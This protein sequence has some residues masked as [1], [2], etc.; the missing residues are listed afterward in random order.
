MSEITFQ[1]LE[2]ALAKIDQVGQGEVTFDVGDVPVTL[3]KMSPEE[4][5]AVND[6]ANVAYEGIEEGDHQT[7]LN[8]LDRFKVAVLSHALVAVGG[9]DF[10][11]VEY[12]ETGEKLNDKPVKEPRH[13]AMRKLIRA[14]FSDNLRS[15]MF[16]KYHALCAQVDEAADKAI[17]F[18]PSDLDS[19]IERLETRAKQLKQRKS[20]EE[21]AAKPS[22]MSQRMQAVVNMDNQDRGRAPEPPIPEA[23]PTDGGP[24][25]DEEPPTDEASPDPSADEPPPAPQ[26]PEERQPISPQV[27]APPVRPP[28]TAQT[29][30]EAQ[31]EPSAEEDPA[32]DPG[33]SVAPAGPLDTFIDEG[34][35][36][37]IAAANTQL[38][39]HRRAK[40]RGAAP[41]AESVLTAAHQ[42]G[43]PHR[44]APHTGIAEGDEKIQPAGELGGVPVFRA[45][46]QEVGA[47]A[48][49]PEDRRGV[50]NLQ[51]DQSTRNPRFRAPPKT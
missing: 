12:V 39:Q 7:V 30:P 51:P 5:T 3:R 50:V 36:E 14:R 49:A 10:R 8:Y 46:A 40:G 45:P 29:P 44:K 47:R 35:E 38:L 18:E 33:P 32:P 19:E 15:G 23:P 6:F 37:A 21:E 43:L 24:S 22:D 25:T 28:E 2:A 48:E 1:A 4:E 42:Q 13:M 16:R 17:E 26:S 11:E 20:Q 34:D 41:P 31:P 9:V 27:G